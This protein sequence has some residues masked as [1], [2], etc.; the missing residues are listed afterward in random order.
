MRQFL[1]RN[2]PWIP[3]IGMALYLIVFFFAALQFP[4]GSFN[5]PEAQGYSF[6]HNFL[7]DVM[8]PVT[9]GGVVN[10]IRM[11]AIVSH[12]VLS[13]TMISFFYLL[14]EIF[15]RRNLNLTV[16]RYAGMVTMFVFIF[17]YTR[18]HDVIVTLTGILGTIA[19]V[20][21]FIELRDYSN[22]G[23]KLLA[24]V[25]FSFSIIVFIIFETKFGFY[26]LPSL[27]KLTFILDA[28]WVI[29]VSL[30][31]MRNNSR[32]LEKVPA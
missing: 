7:C 18:Y 21:F 15:Q 1:N 14:P 19:L 3:I 12:L 22:R 17:M 23:L 6:F 31:V 20:P 26:Y 9:K 27:Q 11:L 32:S 10:P 30:L 5:Y 4:G 28:W 24:W 13:V 29:W 8:D 16:V 25:C 2:Y